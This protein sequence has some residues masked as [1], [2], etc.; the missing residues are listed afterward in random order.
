MVRKDHYDQI[1]NSNNQY[2]KLKILFPTHDFDFVF[3][4]L[5]IS[6][7]DGE[8]MRKDGSE[9]NGWWIGKHQPLG[10]Q[11]LWN[12]HKNGNY[13]P[14]CEQRDN[15]DTDQIATSN[16]MLHDFTSLTVCAFSDIEAADG[17]HKNQCDDG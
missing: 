1:D 11:R 6:W 15:N 8:K 17:Q 10:F 13:S 14:E 4:P 5:Q 16:E 2:A 7:K 9:E 12:H 3:T